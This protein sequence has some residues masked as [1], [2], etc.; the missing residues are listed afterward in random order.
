L[1]I[2]DSQNH[3]ILI[4]D[5]FPTTSQSSADRVLGQSDFLKGVHNDDD[6]DG[7]SD[8]TPSARTLHAPRGIKL[9]A[10]RLF[11]GDGE[12]NRVLIFQPE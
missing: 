1:F 9:I 3:R 11:V 2:A 12:N 10:N 4:F 6:Q 5:S 7:F 8:A